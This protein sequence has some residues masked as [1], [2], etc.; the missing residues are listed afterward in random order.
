MTLRHSMRRFLLRMVLALVCLT[1]PT[2]QVSFA[3]GGDSGRLAG[4]ISSANSPVSGATVIVVD[5]ATGV[6]RTITANAD[7]TFVVPLL[8]PGEYTVKVSAPGFKSVSAEK[9]K[10]DIAREYNLNLS[11]EVG[12]I[13]DTVEVSAGADILNATN[14]ALSATV[15]PKQIIELP[16]NGRNPLSLVSLQ[17][18]VSSNGAQGTS[19][20]GLRTTATN[21]TR[22][23]INVQD[24]FIRTNATDFSP[25]RPSVD[26]TAEF[27]VT[28]QNADASQGYGASQIQVVTPRGG[29]EYHGAAYLFNRNSSLAANNFFN[30]LSG[31]PVPF[32]NRNNFGAKFSGPAPGLGK[33]VFFFFSY[34]GLRQRSVENTPRQRTI[35]T[36][37]ARSGAFTFRNNANQTVVVPNL[38]AFANGLGITGVPTTM[39]STIQSRV[40]SQSPAAGNITTRGDGLNTTGFAFSARNNQDRNFYVSRVDYDI[41]E[42]NTISGV[43]SDTR[44]AN[45]R[46]DADNGFSALPRVTQPS[47]NQLLSL[48]YRYTPTPTFN[49]ELRGGFFR[50]NAT[51][52]RSDPNPS[53]LLALPLI[54]NPELTFQ[55]QGRDTLG[56]N[57]QDN[58]SLQIQKHSLTF[59][60]Q[61]QIFQ[62]DAF[63]AAG[64]VQ[65]F[66]V[67]QNQVTP[68]FTQASFGSL[69]GISPAQVNVANSLLAL[70]G[71]IVSSGTQTFNL[72]DLNSGF[73]PIQNFQPFRYS[74]YSFYAQ[75]SWR[76]LPR[77]TINAGLR[78]EVYPALRLDNGLALLPVIPPGVDPRTAILDPNGTY[79][80]LSRARGGN[81]QYHNTDYNNVAPI[82]S[83]AYSPDFKNSILRAILPGDG[84]TVI[85]GGFRISYIND[86]LVTALNNTAAGNV[87]VG[88]T[89]VNAINAAGSPNLNA[90]F[91][92]LPSFVAPSV[93][94][95]R[96]FAQN[97]GP[98][99]GNFGAVVTPDPNLQTPRTIE[100]NVGIQREV[101]FNMA[102]EVRYV[103][104]RSDN[105]MRSTDL[106]QI[107]IINNGFLADFNRARANL[108]GPTGNALGGQ[109]LS[110]FPVFSRLA[111]S[112]NPNSAQNQNFLRQGLVGNMALAIIQN[113]QSTA[114]VPFRPN[115]NTGAANFLTNSAS[116]RYHSLQVELRK[117]FTSGLF[118]QAN[119]TFQKNLTNAIGTG[120]FLFD[121]LLDNNRPEL[122]RTRADFDQTQVF[123]FNSVYDLPFGKGKR[124]VNNG[125]GLVD[126]LVGGWQVAT[127]VRVGTGA[128]VTFIDQTGTFQR[129]GRGRQTATSSLTTSQLR[130]LTGIFFRPNGTVS[131][132]DPSLVNSTGRGS[133]GFGAN[134]FTGQAFFNA[135]PGQ[136]GN[137]G[138]GS[139]NGPSLFNVD[140]SILKN[141]AV[142]ERFKLQLRLEAFNLFNKAQFLVPQLLDIN[143]QTFGQISAANPARVIQIGAR[144][145]F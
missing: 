84:K 6:E 118:F 8:K 102:L 46:P 45:L 132:V 4:V 12:D 123:N 18:G 131:F 66:T 145:D 98:A 14:G 73:Q 136:T 120:Q 15:S 130:D 1:F 28:T 75:D 26:D 33:K 56:I 124:F 125:N 38:L 128:P 141:L 71:G 126:R 90:R 29:G 121:P 127:I 11:L 134:P 76:V 96:T 27:T 65:V 24:A 51:F 78:Y 48:A 44:E 94:L 114:A 34:E 49:N 37:S 25:S 41:N 58:A 10:I 63:N 93:I 55:N 99:F 109:P 81:N 64:N 67:G 16:L 87:G 113:G 97:N 52:D 80:V 133:E 70:Y 108:L 138:R 139:I 42:K 17:A 89:A 21:I 57:L 13:S 101:G 92:A 9:V 54:E 32:L 72:R 3:Q 111:A 61:A 115:P 40:I 68:Q 100:F 59:G 105:L 86:S 143:S 50:S 103:G 144:L 5:N 119:Y 140:A 77:L 122:E 110:S 117:R 83:A 95:P 142:N 23:G 36:P 20:N 79:D 135:A 2:I 30:N 43:F 60:V 106:N 22:D 129:P 112:F 91:G 69:G 85:R 47:L 62:V 104:G 137:L 19:I 74:N 53:F 82:V 31:L 7:G 35:L 39:D 116:Y 88:A 107:D